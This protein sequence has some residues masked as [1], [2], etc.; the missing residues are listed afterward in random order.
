M[1]KDITALASRSYDLSLGGSN[2]G[3]IEEITVTRSV[4]LRDR[5]VLQLG[6]QVL[7]QVIQSVSVAISAQLREVTLAHLALLCPWFP[8][9]GE[10]LG[11]DPVPLNPEIGTDLYDYAQAAVLHPREL[12][13]DTGQDISLLRAVVIP[14]FELAGDADE[15]AVI[16]VTIRAYPD[17]SELPSIV[18]G[19]IGAAP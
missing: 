3:Y 8:T 15:D 11:T 19:Y 4:E 9:A 5:T 1:A 17:R 12:G 10:V 7:G 2:V 14:D 6:S 13:E 16:P 18:L